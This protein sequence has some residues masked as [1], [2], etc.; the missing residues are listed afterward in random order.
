[1]SRLLDPQTLL[2]I[3]RRQSNGKATRL[4]LPHFNRIKNT[5]PSVSIWRR[6]RVRRNSQLSTSS[7]AGVSK[8]AKTGRVGI[9]GLS[10]ITDLPGTTEAGGTIITTVSF[11]YTVGGMLGTQAI[12]TRLGAT[13]PIRITLTM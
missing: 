13:H 12:G 1:M 3:P 4:L 9:I 11:S 7:K 5:R 2:P 8:A 6:T 10:G